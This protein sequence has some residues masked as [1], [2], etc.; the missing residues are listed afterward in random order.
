LFKVNDAKYP[1]L[2]HL[3][4]MRESVEEVAHLH[5]QLTAGGFEPEE[6]REEQG[7][8]TFYFRAPGEFTVEVNCLLPRN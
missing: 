8:F 6:A 5:Q 3:G 2:F 4:F 1:K 7:R